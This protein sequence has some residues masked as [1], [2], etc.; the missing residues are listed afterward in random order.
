[1][2][3]IWARIDAFD[4]SIQMSFIDSKTLQFYGQSYKKKKMNYANQTEKTDAV[5]D[6][7]P[8]LRWPDIAEKH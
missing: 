1:M 8:E 2:E 3:H 4:N 6:H 7:M 5:A